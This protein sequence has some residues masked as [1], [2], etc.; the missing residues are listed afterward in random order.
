M[1]HRRFI[2]LIL[3]LVLTISFPLGIGRASTSGPTPAS[4]RYQEGPGIPTGFRR[5]HGLAQSA[6]PSITLHKTA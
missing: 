1:T 2:S 5:R 6:S 3:L 4:P